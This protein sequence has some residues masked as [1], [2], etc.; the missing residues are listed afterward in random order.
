MPSDLEPSRC[1]AGLSWAY[2]TP[3]S[4]ILQIDGCRNRGRGEQARLLPWQ[5]ELKPP[6]RRANPLM[7]EG[8]QLG[9]GIR[10]GERGGGDEKGR[11]Y[12]LLNT[13]ITHGSASLSLQMVQ[14]RERQPPTLKR[15]G[16]DFYSRKGSC[17]CGERRIPLKATFKPLEGDEAEEDRCL[18]P[19]ELR[20][21]DA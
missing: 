14:T 13:S 12:P 6:P 7:E 20:D 18:E 19:R 10:T 21:K 11:R 15:E 16:H 8:E 4:S 3:R 9:R 17:F 2:M 5:E 1:T